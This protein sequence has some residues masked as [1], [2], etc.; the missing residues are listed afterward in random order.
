MRSKSLILSENSS[1]VGKAMRAS[2]L[3]GVPS[4]LCGGRRMVKCRRSTAASDFNRLRHTRSP[5]CGSPETRST[6]RFSR[7]PSATTTM[8]LLAA[9]SSPGAVSSSIS[10]MFCPACGKLMGTVSGRPICAVRVVSGLPS[11]RIFEHHALAGA[12]LAPGLD[13]LELDVARGADDAVARCL[14]HLD[15]AVE[16]AGTCRSGA[17]AR[18]HRSPAPAPSSA[19]REPARR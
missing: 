18:A 2:W 7:T 17:R 15:A 9:V 14:D 13:H 1:R 3:S 8:R 11:R 5:A 10:M 12:A 4:C 19:R 16:L 6:R